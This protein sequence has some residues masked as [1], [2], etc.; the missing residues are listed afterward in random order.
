MFARSFLLAAGFIAMVGCADTVSVSPL[1]PDHPANPRAAVAPLPP[2]TIPEAGEDA[3]AGMPSVENLG[4]M[5]G[6]QHMD[7]DSMPGM[8][9]GVLQGMDH[10]K[11]IEEA[12]DTEEVEGM[13]H[14]H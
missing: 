12:Q 8:E 13:H 7:D 11:G 10:G 4:G 2:T 14:G 1:G 9:H 3:R 6:T 5:H